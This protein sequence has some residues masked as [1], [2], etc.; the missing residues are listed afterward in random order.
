MTSL[1]FY[2]DFLNVDHLKVFI[3]FV[4]ILLLLFMFWFFGCDACG[5]FTPQLGIK[6]ISPVLEGE[7]LTAGTAREIPSLLLTGNL[8]DNRNS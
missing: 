1:I 4:T 3:E 2:K 6:P 8:T 5:S 7:V